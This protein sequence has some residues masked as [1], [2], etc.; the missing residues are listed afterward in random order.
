MKPMAI[1]KNLTRLRTGA[2]LSQAGLARL[3][4]VSQQLISQIER[5]ENL[6][7]KHLPRL[8]NALG[9]SVGEIDP[10][11]RGPAPAIRMVR[12]IGAVQAGA[13]REA[14]EWPDEDQYEVPIPADL[15][16]HGYALLAVETRGTSMN[17]RYPEGTILVYTNAI[18]TYEDLRAG[19]RYVIE[20]QRADGER[21]VTVKMLW[22]DETGKPWLLP[23]STDPLFQQP[24]PLEGDEN[25]TIQILGQVRYAVVRE[26]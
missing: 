7:T 20:R 26:D 22:E 12:V 17:R 11:F 18:H 6:S 4:G 23:E 21:E 2:G 1:A 16:L 13:W 14:L 8:A 25:E 10:S 9:V 15:Q 24:I 5:G 3:S 19:K